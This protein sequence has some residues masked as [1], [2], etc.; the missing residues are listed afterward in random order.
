MIKK[1]LIT[2]AVSCLLFICAVSCALSGNLSLSSS[3]TDGNA[4]FTLKNTEYFNDLLDDLTAWTGGSEDPV[5]D[6]VNSAVTVLEEAKPA[7]NIHSEKNGNTSVISFNFENLTALTQSLSKGKEQ[8]LLKVEECDGHKKLTL[9]IDSSSFESIEK[10]FSFMAETGFEICSKKYNENME[11]DEYVEML[12][13]IFSDEIAD[14]IYASSVNLC[15]A[16]PSEIVSTNGEKTGSNTV[17]FNIPLI[18]I[19][20]LKEPVYFEVVF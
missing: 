14:E 9:L 6:A 11:E 3:K 7:F 19:M 15:F 5:L 18:K 20:L 16:L 4:V 10:L 12:Q 8:N 1:L 2:S 17:C 13:F